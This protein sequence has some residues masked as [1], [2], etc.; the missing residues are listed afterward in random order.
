MMTMVWR[1]PSPRPLG[2]LGSLGIVIPSGFS[3]ARDLHLGLILKALLQLA[4]AVAFIASPA[5]ASDTTPSATP[6]MELGSYAVLG[7]GFSI[8]HV[9]RE[10]I[11]DTTRL[12]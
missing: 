7:N 1:S 12:Y 2:E 9:R 8:R 5:L 11:G 3:S 6:A 4:I 10:V